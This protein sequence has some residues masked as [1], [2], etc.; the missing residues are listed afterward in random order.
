MEVSYLQPHS[1]PLGQT[2]DLVSSLSNDW[3]IQSPVGEILSLENKELQLVFD[4]NDAN[5]SGFMRFMCEIDGGNK[6]WKDKYFPTSK[7]KQLTAGTKFSCKLLP[8]TDVFDPKGGMSDHTKLAPK[9]RVIVMLKT[10]SVWISKRNYG[11]TW[12]AMQI[13]LQD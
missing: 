12:S 1:T 4:T 3:E 8:K 7:Q 13:M 6:H 5:Y 9:Q 10:P 11:N 2:S